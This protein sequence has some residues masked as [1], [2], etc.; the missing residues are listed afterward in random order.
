MSKP[1]LS[2][3]VLGMVEAATLGMA[4][5]AAAKTAQGHRVLNLSIGE[6]DFDTPAHIKDAAKKALDDGY[7]S[8]TPVQGLPVLR[9]AICEKFKR[10]NDLDFE[11][12]Q[13]AVSCGA[14]QS[15]ANIMLAMLDPGDEVILPAPYWVSYTS[16]I[17]QAAGVPV[18]IRTDV[19]ADFKITPD[20]LEQAITVKTRLFLFSNPCNPTGSVYS[21]DELRALAEIVVSYGGLFVVSDEIYEYI[22]FGGADEDGH[23]SIGA[24]DGMRDRTIT[25]NGFSKGFAMTGW[26][27]GYLGGPEW[28]ARAVAKVQGQ[29][30]SGAAAF[31]QVA[32]AHALRSDLAASYAMRDTYRRRRDQV[33][34]GLSEIPG[35]ETTR[36]QGAFYSFSDV[37]SYYG[38]RVGERVIKGSEDFCRYLLDEANVATVP[39]AAFGDDRCFRIS[40]AASDADLKEALERI[41]GAL[42]ALQ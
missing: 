3:R 13:I 32:A 1:L 31:S 18:T 16:L 21:R 40:F 38:K 22:H 37:S 23:V 19:G 36:P 24:L 10:D 34:S 26:R 17:T 39:G 41:K 20:E 8:Y 35:I 7:T 15:L 6:P 2:K 12:N 42:A 29:F 27:L 25:V 33:M 5:A 4:A 14:K 11:P 28:L 9:E 30:T